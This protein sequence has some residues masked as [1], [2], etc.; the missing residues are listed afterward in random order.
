MEKAPKVIRRAIA[1]EFR[2]DAGRVNALVIVAATLL[3]TAAGGRNL[4]EQLIAV[5]SHRYVADFPVV[6]V[7]ALLLGGGLICVALLILVEELLPKSPAR[8]RQG[9]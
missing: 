4:L 8:R 9:P 5:W 2:T 1:L 7:L 6:P 3:M